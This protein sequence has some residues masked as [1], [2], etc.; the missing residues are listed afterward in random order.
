[1]ASRYFVKN[2]LTDLKSRGII[3][4]LSTVNHAVAGESW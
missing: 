1:M 4:K 3:K 2:H